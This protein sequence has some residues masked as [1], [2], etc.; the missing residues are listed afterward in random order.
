M[1]GAL[2]EARSC[3]RFT[4]L[5]ERLK[6]ADGP[7]ADLLEDLGPAER[8]HWELFHRLAARELPVDEF[9]R[10]WTAWLEHEDGLVAAAGTEPTVHG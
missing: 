8:R 5:Y 10:R 4:L 2:I 9:E 1:V 3:E 7:V 6:G